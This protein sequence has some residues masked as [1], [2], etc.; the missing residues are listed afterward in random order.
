MKI[1]RFML[2]ISTIFLLTIYG[3]STIPANAPIQ[4]R[5]I[6]KN[7]NSKK[8][9]EKF[10]NESFSDEN[11]FYKVKKGDN[12]LKIAKDLEVSWNKILS[13]NNI[14]N[15]NEIKEGQILRIKPPLQNQYTEKKDN[16]II[17][18][19]KFLKKTP[20]GNKIEWSQKSWSEINRKYKTIKKISEK[21]VLVKKS[22]KNFSWPTAGK[23]INVFNSSSKGI[24]ISGIFGQPIFASSRGKVLYAN[25]MR[26][27]GNLIIIEHTDG[28][29]TAYANNK[30][31]NV[32]EGEFVSRGQKI[33]EMGKSDSEIVK[34]HFEIR[35]F[36]KPIDPLKFLPKQ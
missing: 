2:L 27:Y 25:N 3:C 35:K 14:S 23:I 10:D 9:S 28:I 5:N 31:L 30:S 22:L 36:G 16:L 29:V 1:E 33:A 18:K 15:P 26:G 19:N 4:E 32:K 11:I 7:K 24:D 21:K 34:L 6:G 12:L 8:L 20:L 17:K 13:W